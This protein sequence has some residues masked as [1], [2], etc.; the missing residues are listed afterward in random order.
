LFGDAAVQD[1]TR[2]RNMRRYDFIN[3]FPRYSAE[4]I[5]NEERRATLRR[6][7][8][9]VGFAV[10]VAGFAGYMGWNAYMA[11]KEKLDERN[12]R[13]ESNVMSITGREMLNTKIE[14]ERA[15]RKYAKE[16]PLPEKK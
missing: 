8:S 9:L 13:Y 12:Q 3:S 1:D 5:E 6:R 7:V 16:H 4:D 10:A 11:V 14:L 2:E 15:E